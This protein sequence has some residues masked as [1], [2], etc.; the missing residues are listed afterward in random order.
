MFHNFF[1]CRALS[2]SWAFQ[3][4][5]AHFL[6]PGALIAIGHSLH[7]TILSWRHLANSKQLVFHKSFISAFQHICPSVWSKYK[8]LNWSMLLHYFFYK[9]RLLFYKRTDNETY[10]LDADALISIP[11]E[12]H[13]YH[14]INHKIDLYRRNSGWQFLIAVLEVGC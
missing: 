14:S 11:C 1:G 13:H 8:Y 2:V 10:Q 6:F 3:I 9:V 12:L 5:K 4:Q 7:M